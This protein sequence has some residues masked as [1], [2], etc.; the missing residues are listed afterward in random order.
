MRAWAFC[1]VAVLGFSGCAGGDDDD[2]MASSVP[3]SNKDG[4]TGSRRCMDEDGDGFGR[5]CVAGNDCDDEDPTVTDECT[6]CVVPNKNCPC[7]PG[8]KPLYCD[9]DDLHV[10]MNGQTGV[11][12]CSEG[13]RYCR[14]EVWSDCEILFQY[15]TFIP[16]K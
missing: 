4:G 3:T 9:P 13:T 14:D 2:G 10:T 6:R 7:E 12:V 11:L 16:D 8:T 15:A 5:Y 1:V